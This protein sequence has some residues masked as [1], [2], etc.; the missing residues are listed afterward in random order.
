ML[1]LFLI[2][3]NEAHI[4]DRCLDAAQPLVDHTLIVDTGSTD[5]TINIAKK[6]AL[7]IEQPWVNFGHNR[8]QSFQAV[9]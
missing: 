7:V 1:A 6:R 9:V 3:K 4:L 5:D 8:S 2:V